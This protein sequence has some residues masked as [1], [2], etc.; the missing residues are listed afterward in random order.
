[1]RRSSAVTALLTAGLLAAGAGAAF[2]ASLPAAAWQ[3]DELSGTVAVDSSGNGNDGV[4]TDVV[5]GLPSPAGLAYGFNGVS[6]KVE[7]P[8]SGTLNPGSDDFSYSAMVRFTTVPP[9]S[10][11]T[12]DLLRK[13]LSATTGG[14][15]KLEIINWRGSARARCIAKDSSGHVARETFT[16]PSLAD[17]QWHT[18]GC[19]LT[20]DTW[21]VSVDGASE[22]QAVTITSIGNT[23]AL[24]LGT[25]KGGRTG[26]DW[27]EG[28]MAFARVDVG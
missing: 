5:M 15:Y 21:A 27:F 4:A 8:S 7:V 20:G 12:Y 18:I 19:S 17:G 26:G 23:N 10:K 3:L 25:K 22:T 13:G 1:M 9:T 28:E 24:T 2:G 16:S 11:G 14:E 6:S